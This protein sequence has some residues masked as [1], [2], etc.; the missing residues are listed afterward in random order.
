MLRIPEILDPL[1]DI[2]SLISEAADGLE[3]DITPE[4]G[5]EH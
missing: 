4:A 2:L 1:Q 5:S 3:A